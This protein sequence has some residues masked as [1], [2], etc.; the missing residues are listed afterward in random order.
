MNSNLFQLGRISLDSF[1][2]QWM[3]TAY[4]YPFE[5]VNIFSQIFGIELIKKSFKTLAFT[6]MNSRAIFKALTLVTPSPHIGS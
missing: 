1:L 5:A 6:D 4:E 3:F 2:A